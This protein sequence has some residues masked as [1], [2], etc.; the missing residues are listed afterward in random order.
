[1]ARR[2]LLVLALSALALCTHAL[3]S[4][5]SAVVSLTADNFRKELKK[6]GGAMV[7]FYAP[8]CVGS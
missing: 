4:S 1:M 5:G 8:W 6:A 3:Y 2:L 7:E